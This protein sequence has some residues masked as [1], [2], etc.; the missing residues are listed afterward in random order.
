MIFFK[1]SR[2]ARQRA[3]VSCRLGGLSEG[4]GGV[5]LGQCWRTTV[6]VTEVLHNRTT[7][8]TGNNEVQVAGG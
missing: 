8:T 3:A 5:D 1:Q 4:S 7:D 2:R 6:Q